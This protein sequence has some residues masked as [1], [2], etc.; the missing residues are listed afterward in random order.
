MGVNVGVN[1]LTA[2]GLGLSTILL[3]V[4]GIL[5]VSATK[6][7]ESIP[8]F[9]D[10]SK[11]KKAKNDLTTAYTLIF[12]AAGL[13]L[14]LGIAY[15][16]HEVAWCPSEWVHGVL[17]LLVTVALVIG[18]VYAYIAL[19]DIYSPEVDN[20]NGS[21]S[22]IWA[23]MLIG[24]LSFMVVAATGSGR[25]GYN[26]ARNDVRTRVRHAEDKVH[27]MHSAV[28][29]KQNDFVPPKD[30]CESCEEPEAPCGQAPIPHG[31]ML[32]PVNQNVNQGPVKLPTV[33][34]TYQNQTYQPNYQQQVVGP[35]TCL[36]YTSPSP[37]D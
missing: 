31:M 5:L 3:V 20:D 26:V 16:G 21:T 23:A 25:V 6:K 29:G 14:L 18:I 11:L 30:R 7:V 13:T 17:Y 12:I 9:E 10:S 2:G 32:V 37:R 19:Y 1:S 34:Q 15:G 4:M 28:T 8:D 36:L 33:S 35:P 22:F 27:E 24:A